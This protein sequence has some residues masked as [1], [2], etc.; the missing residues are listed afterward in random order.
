[1]VNGGGRL[2]HQVFLFWVP[3]LVVAIDDHHGHLKNLYSHQSASVQKTCHRILQVNMQNA[4]LRK[5]Q[6][7]TCLVL[8][9]EEMWSDTMY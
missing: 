2:L 8:T 9:Q 6:C 5:H 3:N 1:M 4:N 7:G